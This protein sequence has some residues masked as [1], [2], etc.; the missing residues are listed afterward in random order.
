[1]RRVAITGLGA[2]T[3]IG[4]DA[5]STWKA[6]VAGSSGIDFIRSFDASLGGLGGCPYAPGASGNIA[7]EDLVFMLDAMGFDTGIRL[8]ALIDAQRVLADLLPGQTFYGKLAAAG[9]PKT[10]RKAA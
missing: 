4:N 9:L 5:P 3:P 6:A 2:V 8:D 1:M 7:T 10:Y